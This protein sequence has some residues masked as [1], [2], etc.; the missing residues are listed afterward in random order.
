MFC[1]AI[2]EI[3]AGIKCVDAK[4]GELALQYLQDEKAPLPD[5]IFLDL[6]MPRLSGKQCLVE[7]K[8]L[9]HL[10]SIPVII[11]STSNHPQDKE[12]TKQLGAFGF[13]HKPTKFDILCK[14]LKRF[15]IPL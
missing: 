6:N 2:N 12:Q 9:D 15:I 4:N 5:F 7:I 11:Y 14:E 8:K 10:R 13:L 3:D 1:E